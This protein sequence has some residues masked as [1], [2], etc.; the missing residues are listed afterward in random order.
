MFDLLGDAANG[1]IE[2]LNQIPGINIETRFA[3]PA[4]P[5]TAEALGAAMGPGAPEALSNSMVPGVPEAMQAADQANMA[6]KAQQTINGA[7]P[8]L[9]PAG[10]SEVPTG[11]LMQSF[12][13]NTTQNKG[14]QIGKVEIHTSQPMS[15]HE[16]DKMLEMAAG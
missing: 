6:T 13:N 14:T 8:S 9:L 7:I 2:L 16:L 15:Q 1:L 3:T 10:P 5:G 12:Q 11:G 4:A